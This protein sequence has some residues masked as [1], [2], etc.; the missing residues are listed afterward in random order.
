M[1]KFA[2]ILFLV[3]FSLALPAAQS[4][5]QT[6]ALPAGQAETIPPTGEAGQEE[7]EKP[8]SLS[9]GEDDGEEGAEAETEEGEE[10][11]KAEEKE[12][13]IIIMRGPS[14]GGGAGGQKINPPPKVLEAFYKQQWL[15][16]ASQF[17]EVNKLAGWSDWKNKFD[18]KLNTLEDLDKALSDLTVFL[19]DRWTVYTSRAEIINA[20]KQHKE[21]LIDIGLFLRK[22]KDGAF[23]ID[24]ISYGSPTHSSDLKEGDVIKSVNGKDVSGMTNAEA[25]QLLNGKAGDK[26]T[27]VA[28]YDGA[29]HSLELTYTAPEAQ[30]VDLDMLPGK[31]GYIRLPTF[32]SDEIAAKFIESLAEL[33]QASKGELNGLVFDLRNN[34]GGKVDLSIKLSSLFLEHGTIVKTKMRSSR[35]VQE[36]AYKTIPA[37]QYLEDLLPG[38]ASEFGHML[39]TVPIV[40]LINGSTA[41]ASEITTGC[42]QDNGRAWVV[43]THSFGKAVG[44]QRFP[45][46]NGGIL[47]ITNLSYLTPKDTD[48]ADKGIKPNEVVENERGSADDLQLKAAHVHLMKIVKERNKQL[49]QARSLANEGQPV[50]HPD[51]VKLEPRV[52][53]YDI[54]LL[55]GGSA[56]YLF[57]FYHR[58]R[59]LRW[60]RRR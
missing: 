54:L 16:I 38:Q 18:G 59:M 37:P 17:A 4:L 21:G 36:T 47:Q 11:K 14:M 23:H 40:I 42:L 28:N 25:N 41:S 50:V 48:I 1:N 51:E 13:E 5:A 7:K 27:I 52:P 58:H 26:V 44:Y 12:E 35:N 29:D 31:I 60:R 46:E 56:V 34:G 55:G 10:G 6:P 9:E 33:Y 53:V 49:S 19:G 39:Q 20:I 2:R 57:L 30:D 43:G 24:A 45:L 22:H 32:M 3:M 8:V 15:S